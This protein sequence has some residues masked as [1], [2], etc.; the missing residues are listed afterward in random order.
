[1][2]D[3]HIEIEVHL[4]RQTDLAGLFD[5]EEFWLPWSQIEDNGEDLRNG[6]TGSIFVA[7]WLLIQKGL[8]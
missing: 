4:I 2:S 8:L 5:G 7:E 1:M 3:E 6:Y